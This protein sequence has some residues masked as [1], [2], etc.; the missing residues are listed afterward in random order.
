MEFYTWL[1]EKHFGKNSRTGDLAMDIANDKKFPKYGTR[2]EIL[3]HL[4]FMNASDAAIETF[5]GAWRA[6]ER[7]EK[8]KK[9]SYKEL[10][11]ELFDLVIDFVNNGKGDEAWS[12]AIERAGEIGSEHSDSR[13][14]VIAVIEELERR[15]K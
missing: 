13:R 3:L 2:D 5:K 11:S 6:Y 1:I 7:N 8:A 15:Y 9:E 4:Y 12:N 10:V 14:A